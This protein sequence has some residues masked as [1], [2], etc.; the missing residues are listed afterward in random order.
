MC[1]IIDTSKHSS[2]IPIITNKDVDC[3]KWLLKS[4]TNRWITPWLGELIKFKNGYCIQS[5]SK[6][7][8]NVDI[9]Y[10]SIQEGIHSFDQKV[11][12]RRGHVFP[13]IIP[14]GTEM[15]YGYLGRL[16]PLKLIIFKTKFHRWLYKKGYLKIKE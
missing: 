5:T 13:A 1:L 12:S 14:K 2:I 11:S 8:I 7:G 4:Y 10:N 16:V 3:D 15:Y 9:E 6:F